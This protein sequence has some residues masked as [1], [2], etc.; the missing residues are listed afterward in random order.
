MHIDGET[1]PHVK[2]REPLQWY[3]AS[4]GSVTLHLQAVR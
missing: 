2:R 3:I 4:L 1:N